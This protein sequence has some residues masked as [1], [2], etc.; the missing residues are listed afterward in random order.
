MLAPLQP[1]HNVQ[2]FK[3]YF[4]EEKRVFVE[5]LPQKQYPPAV[6]LDLSPEALLLLHENIVEG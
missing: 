4:A 6:I 2:D 1:S 5:P 3:H